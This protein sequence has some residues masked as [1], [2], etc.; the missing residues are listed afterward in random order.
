MG[1]GGGGG[2]ENC[3]MTIIRDGIFIY[4]FSLTEVSESLKYT[5][6]QNSR[7]R[8]E[9][10]QLQTASDQRTRKLTDA[11]RTRRGHIQDQPDG[12]S[13]HPFLR[14]TGRMAF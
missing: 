7:S 4:A 10:T 14:C 9:T 3:S 5:P 1:R 13:Y 12:Q 8:I 2:V 6:N 11:E